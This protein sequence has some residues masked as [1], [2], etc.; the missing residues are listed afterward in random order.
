[1]RLGHLEFENREPLARTKDP[2]S[3]HE[4]GRKLT[5]SGQRSTGKALVLQSLRLLVGENGVP[6]T[7]A[8]L[9]EKAGLDRY[10]VAR[11]LPD[12]R[13]DGWAQKCEERI[14]TVSRYLALTWRP[15][16]RNEKL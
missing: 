12:L 11:R 2:R 1:M 16:R 8:E 9:A 6:L 7:S 3:S 4:A 14:C 15:T 5:E 13:R 10:M